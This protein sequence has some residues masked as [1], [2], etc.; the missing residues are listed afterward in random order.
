MMER[1]KSNFTLRLRDV[2]W[3]YCCNFGSHYISAGELK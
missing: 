1:D 2:D 3:V